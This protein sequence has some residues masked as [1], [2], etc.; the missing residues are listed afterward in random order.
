MSKITSKNFNDSLTAV[1][2]LFATVREKIQALLEF[3]MLQASQGNYTYINMLIANA[4]KLKGISMNGI[5][6]YVEK[7]C[8][9]VLESKAGVRAFTN[10]KTKGFSFVAPTTPWY[11]DNNAGAVVIVDLD[12][13]VKSLITKLSSV[14]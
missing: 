7:H 4:G 14:V 5:Q 3:A 1:I 11:E 13:A 12:Q 10:K 6:M 2:G 8:D 9:V